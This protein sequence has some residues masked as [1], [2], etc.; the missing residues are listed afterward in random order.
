MKTWA[1]SIAP[2]S[3]VL[4]GW[5]ILFLW[6]TRS[7]PVASADTY[8]FTGLLLNFNGE[9]D[10]TFN[11]FSLECMHD[12]MVDVMGGLKPGEELSNL[13][14]TDANYMDY[15][16]TLSFVLNSTNSTTD[17]D[18]YLAIIENSFANSDPTDDTSFQ[19]ILQQPA[20]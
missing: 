9:T 6:S 20:F 2:S 14:M 4:V 10:L 7:V 12:V 3:V 5:Y 8:E 16:H 1:T 11:T 15:T 17:A 13:T 19:A 18:A